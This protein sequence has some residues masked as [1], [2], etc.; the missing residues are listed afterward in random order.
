MTFFDGDKNPAAGRA[1]F[2]ATTQGAFNRRA[3]ALEINDVRGKGNRSVGRRW[4]QQLDRI[5]CRHRAGRAIFACVF[6]QVISRCPITVTIKERAYDSAI[7]NA[8]KCFVFFL[9]LP[10]GHDFTVF[11][12]TANV[13]A[14]RI[15]WTATEAGI[16]RCV[17]FLKRSLTH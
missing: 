4:S 2:S 17:F 11:G 5:L 8:G 3:I 6:H 9:G 10:L 1:Y 15:G 13:Q 7:Q 12:K 16:F 14:I